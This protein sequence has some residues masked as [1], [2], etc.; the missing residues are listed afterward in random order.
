MLV[1]LYNY[2]DD[3]RSNKHKF[4]LQ[5]LRGNRIALESIL[6]L[7]FCALLINYYNLNQQMLTILLDLK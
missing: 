5:G 7:S 4:H 6:N 2:Q 3:G 1:S